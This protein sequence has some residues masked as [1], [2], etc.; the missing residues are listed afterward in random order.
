[1]HV[2]VLGIG[3]CA[4]ICRSMSMYVYMCC[5]TRFLGSC[6]KCPLTPDGEPRAEQSRVTTKVAFGKSVTCT[7]ASHRSVYE[8]LVTEAEVTQRL[9]QPHHPAPPQEE[10][11]SEPGAWSSLCSLRAAR[12]LGQCRSGQTLPPPR[13]SAHSG[14]GLSPSCSHM[15]GEGGSRELLFSVTSWRLFIVSFLG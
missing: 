10:D 11:N 9:R 1:M 3:I 6:D 8:G 2:C 14:S 5:V 7:G 12:P 13:V 4:Y 15:L